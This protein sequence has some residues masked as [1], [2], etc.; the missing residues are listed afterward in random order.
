VPPDVDNYPYN[1]YEHRGVLMNPTLL[2]LLYSDWF[3]A[4]VYEEFVLMG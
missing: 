2:R 1:F 4:L 3:N